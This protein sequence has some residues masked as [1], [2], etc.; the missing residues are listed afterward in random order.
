M[1]EFTPRGEIEIKGKGR[2]RTFFLVDRRDVRVGAG[3]QTAVPRR[4]SG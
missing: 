2:M 1:Y 4:I 3:S